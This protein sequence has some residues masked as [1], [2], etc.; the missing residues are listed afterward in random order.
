MICPHAQILKYHFIF[1]KRRRKW[2]NTAGGQTDGM[3]L[4]FPYS[5]SF[6]AE[7]DEFYHVHIKG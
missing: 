3:D 2:R 5:K 7:E 6:P 1:Y 4:Y